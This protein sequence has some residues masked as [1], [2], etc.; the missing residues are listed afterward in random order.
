[1]KDFVARHPLMV[2]GLVAGILL[3]VALVLVNLYSYFYSLIVIPALVIYVG[4]FVFIQN[5]L[6]VCTKCGKETS[7]STR[8]KYCSECGSV[9]GLIKKEKLRSCPN[10]HYVDKSDKF[11]PKCKAP[12]EKR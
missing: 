4:T 10:G 11:C 8:H 2:G 3:V 9:M 6:W 12:L 5:W 7:W 1:M